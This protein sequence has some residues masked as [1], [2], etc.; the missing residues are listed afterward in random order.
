MKYFFLSFIF[1][2]INCDQPNK[3]V[4]KENS[5]INEQNIEIIKTQEE[6]IVVIKDIINLEDAKSLVVNSGLIW[7]KMALDTENTKA[8][9]LKVPFDKKDFWLKRLQESNVFS[10][11]EIKSDSTL[12]H[13]KYNIENTFV[14]L[15]KTHCSGVCPVYDVVFY[16]NGKVVFNG[17]DN[18]LFKGKQEF[19]ITKKQQDNLIKMFS[20]TSFKNYKNALITKSIAD[21]PSTYITHQNKQIEIKLWKNVP[22]ELAFAYQS[23]EDILLDKKLID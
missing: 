23:L 19:T 3:K 4:E 9:Y 13:I 18:V 15:R 6:F 22:D 2:A 1:L 14:K 17:I 11:V 10:S 12:E 5:K 8:V 21:F 20:K 16:K 7:D